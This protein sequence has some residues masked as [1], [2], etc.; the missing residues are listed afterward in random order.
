MVV[1]CVEGAFKPGDFAMFGRKAGDDV[2]NSPFSASSSFV[3]GS[4]GDISKVEVGVLR[5]ESGGGDPATG[6]NPVILFNLNFD[7]L[8][9]ALSGGVDAPAIVCPPDIAGRPKF[10][11]DSW[12]SAGCGDERNWLGPDTVEFSAESNAGPMLWI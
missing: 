10:P 4:F 3:A 12:L 8:A 11:R 5:L 6:C 7:A 9:L 2:T 1:N